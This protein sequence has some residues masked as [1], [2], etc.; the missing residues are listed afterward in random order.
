MKRDWDV[1][2][3]VL[4]TVR[5]GEKD[6]LSKKAFLDETFGYHAKIM[7]DEGCFLYE[8][9]MDTE[10]EAPK[11]LTWKGHDL[12]DALELNPEAVKRGWRGD[13]PHP[14]VSMR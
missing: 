9:D 1:V 7:I 11:Y 5:S 2:K 8:F 13:T 6:G 4:E 12:L 10:R 3:D 14:S